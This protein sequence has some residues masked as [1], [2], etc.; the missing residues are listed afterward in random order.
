[1]TKSIIAIV[2]RPNVGKSTLFN[3]LA[4]ERRA[5]TED[6]P[7]TTR[8]R[9]YATIIWLDEDFTLVDT[10]GL[11]LSPNSLIAQKIKEQVEVAIEEADAIIMLVDVKEGV[12]IP[13]MEIAETLRRSNKPVVLAV[14]KCDNDER[15]QQALEFHEMPLVE[16]ITISAYHATGID[17]LMEKITAGLDCSSSAF[18]GTL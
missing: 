8:D 16:P 17:T 12:T 7:G 14:N 10:G 11:E 4:G 6:M 13:D 9:F 1:M 2:G 3:R 5:I 15:I 18:S